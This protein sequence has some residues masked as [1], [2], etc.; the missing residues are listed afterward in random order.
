MKNKE[1]LKN[2]KREEDERLNYDLE[3]GRITQLYDFPITGY[4]KIKPA[5]V[6]EYRKDGVIYVEI[7]IDN[8]DLLSVFRKIFKKLVFELNNK[9]YVPIIFQPKYIYGN[10]ILILRPADEY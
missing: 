10:I 9:K 5:S 8:I 2:L 7:L 1:L 6:I 3:K 4:Y